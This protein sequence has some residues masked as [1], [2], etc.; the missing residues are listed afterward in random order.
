MLLDNKQNGKVGEELRRHLSKGSKL[1]VLSGLFSI[2][3]FDWLKKELSSVDEIRLLL[4]RSLKTE[5]A[6]D[7]PFAELTGD[8]F[9][10]RLRNQLN[11]MQIAKEC[12]QWIERKVEVRSTSMAN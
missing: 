11:Q 3:G 9:E 6:H 8:R 7:T 12:A 10:H 5:I 4:S 1:S 2:Y